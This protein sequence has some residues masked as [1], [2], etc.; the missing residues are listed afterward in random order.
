MSIYYFH[1][2]LSLN[3]P[4]NYY[5]RVLLSTSYKRGNGSE[6]LPDLLSLTGRKLPSQMLMNLVRQCPFNMM[7]LC[8]LE[9]RVQFWIHSS[10]PVTQSQ[11][12]LYS[13]TL[14]FLVS[15]MQI[16]YPLHKTVE[17]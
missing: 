6:A 10:E 8:H 11:L 4:N 3:H 7:Q 15:K 14:C 5:V 12:L 1:H 17:D 2:I 13:L 16:I 9:G